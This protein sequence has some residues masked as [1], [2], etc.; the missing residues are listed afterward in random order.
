VTASY[1]VSLKKSAEKELR[2]IPARDITKIV[3]K[4]KNLQ[5]QPRPHGCEKMEGGERYRIRQGDWRVI[6]TID[7]TEKSVLVIKIG[8][9]REVYR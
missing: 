3:D 7:D 8:N 5:Q 1:K 2:S 6:Y 9:R 4:I